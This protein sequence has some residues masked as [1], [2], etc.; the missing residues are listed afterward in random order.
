MHQFS[1]GGGGPRVGPRVGQSF[2]LQARCDAPAA[3]SGRERPKCLLS[4]QPLAL[5]P[6]CRPIHLRPLRL[7]PIH[8][9]HFFYVTHLGL[10]SVAT[11][12]RQPTPFRCESWHTREKNL[13]SG[14]RA[15]THGRKSSAGRRDARCPCEHILHH[16]TTWHLPAHCKHTTSHCSPSF[17]ARRHCRVRR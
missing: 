4:A 13:L 14:A 12:C 11:C 7:H 5:H 9:L 15:G 3:C 2:A 8:L 6:S 1:F 16:A 10:C 17:A